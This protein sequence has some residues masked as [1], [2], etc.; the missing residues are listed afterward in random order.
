MKDGKI[1]I[2]IFL[3]I[4]K[5]TFAQVDTIITIPDADTTIAFTEVIDTNKTPFPQNLWS[6]DPHSVGRAALYSAVIPGLGQAYNG[7]YWKIPIVYAALGTGGY[8]IY[9]NSII[10]KDL[11]NTYILRTDA[12]STTNDDYI[13]VYGSEQYVGDITDDYLLTYV[14]T[15][16]RYSDLAVIITSFLYILNIVDAVVDAHLYDFNVSDDLSLHIRPYFLPK[17]Y[18]TPGSY[19]SFGINLN[20]SLK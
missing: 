20:F 7:K 18:S 15:W 9:A 5:F 12:D 4:S 11:K 1:F 2:I 17:N 6:H 3:L 8:F 14:D 13:N 10:Y 16:K 19:N